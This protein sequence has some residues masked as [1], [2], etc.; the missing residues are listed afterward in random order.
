MHFVNNLKHLL[1][2]PV[3]LAPWMIRAQE[4]HT[5]TKAEINASDKPEELRFGQGDHFEYFTVPD[6]RL[7]LYSLPERFD[8]PETWQKKEAANIAGEP[9]G[10]T[11][12]QSL[13]LYKALSVID[14]EKDFRALCAVKSWCIAYYRDIFPHLVARLSVK[15]K[16]GLENSA[17]L[18]I[19]DRLATGDLKFYGHG[20]S[21]SEDLFTVAGRASW[22]L[23]EITGESFARVHGNLSREQAEGF[24]K[25]WADYINRLTD[26]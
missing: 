12:D 9:Y 3:C 16:V 26:F 10:G 15:Q 22:I 6:N 4:I 2:L 13:T 5:F 11:P 20:G 21:I 17:D 19:S 1:L 25:Q 18:I 14:S 24:K 23:N 7:S 8:K